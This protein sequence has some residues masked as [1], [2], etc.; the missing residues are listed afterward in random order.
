[1]LNI[2]CSLIRFLSFILVRLKRHHFSLYLKKNWAQ[3]SDMLYINII[4]SG[5]L[6]F[7]FSLI[8]RN[9]R[10]INH[11]FSETCL[12]Y[13]FWITTLSDDY[14]RVQNQFPWN[15]S[16]YKEW[17][18]ILERISTAQNTLSCIAAIMF[19]IKDD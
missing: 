15:P 14:L 1:M 2:E 19:I 5:S 18:K 6:N 4:A 8:V 3:L 17:K 13:T 11:L 12:R 7:W 16:I 10:L 9:I